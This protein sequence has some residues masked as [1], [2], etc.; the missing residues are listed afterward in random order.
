ML[1]GRSVN[2][3]GRGGDT[4]LHAAADTGNTD[5]T[6]LLLAR[7]ADPLRRNANGETPLDI[8]RR[9]WG[10]GAGGGAGARARARAGGDIVGVLEG[11]REAA[12]AA[13]AE[14]EAE[15]AAKRG[16]EEYRGE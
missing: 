2:S 6:R 12:A 15:K 8:A 16:H 13:M 10:G 11:A 1:Q 7:G 3:V 4:P 14:A 5:A 9:R